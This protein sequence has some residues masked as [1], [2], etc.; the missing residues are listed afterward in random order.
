[1]WAYGLILWEMIAL[2]PPHV[3]A[4]EDLNGSILNNT[5]DDSV[6]IDE[7]TDPKTTDLDDSN[8]IPDIKV[9][10]NLGKLIIN[11]IIIFIY[12]LF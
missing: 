7:N 6:I 11:K 3:D 1:M 12:K 9:N 2:S 5:M 10:E 8:L 4:D